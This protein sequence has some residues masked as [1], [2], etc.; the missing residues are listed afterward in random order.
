MALEAKAVLE[1]GTSM[2]RVLVGEMRDDG[3]VMVTAVGEAESRG[4]RKGE[5]VNRDN[6]IASVRKAIK[7]A[8]ESR[9]QAA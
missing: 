4:I 3:T 5:I 2:V 7:A 8:E 1:I 6:A 9:R